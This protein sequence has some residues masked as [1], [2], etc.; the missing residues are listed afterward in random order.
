MQIV[1][2]ESDLIL[3]I[4]ITDQ[5]GRYKLTNVIIEVFT[6]NKDAIMYNGGSIFINKK[7]KM[8]LCITKEDLNK[9]NE[10]IISYTYTINSALISY[11]KGII[12]YEYLGSN[13]ENSKPFGDNSLQWTKTV[14][15]DYYLKDN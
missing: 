9:L 4:N 8:S 11:D 10:G 13:I 5:L 15:T 6:D 3:P 2:K 14:Q 7:G 1:E 12:Y